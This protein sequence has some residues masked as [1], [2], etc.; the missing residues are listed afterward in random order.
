MKGCKQSISLSTPSLLPHP[1]LHFSILQNDCRRVGQECCG[2][3]GALRYELRVIDQCPIGHYEANLSDT[4]SRQEMSENRLPM[5]YRDSCAH[6][7]I[8]LNRCRQAEYYLP[9][10]CEVRSPARPTYRRS[11]SA[12]DTTNQLISMIFSTGRETF[13]REVPVRRIQEACG[14]DG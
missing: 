8:P 7:L 9:W 1:P 13:L 3:R 4:A 11:C 10:K 5:Q 12:F 14:Q 6:L 2:P